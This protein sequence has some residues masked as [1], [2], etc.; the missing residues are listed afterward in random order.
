M[1]DSLARS[2]ETRSR[3]RFPRDFA[4]ITRTSQCLRQLPSC[5]AVYPRDSQ[6]RRV[7]CRFSQKLHSSSGFTIH[8]YRWQRCL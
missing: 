6:S 4:L 8:L 7:L 5:V 1:F 2:F 3:P